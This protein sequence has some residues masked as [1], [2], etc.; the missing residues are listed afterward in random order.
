MVR[1]R[2][3]MRYSILIAF[4]IRGGY[5][6]GIDRIRRERRGKRINAIK[7][8]RLYHYFRMNCSEINKVKLK[9]F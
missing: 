9:G 7:N 3:T 4:T 5:I 1:N 6:S 8:S 2:I